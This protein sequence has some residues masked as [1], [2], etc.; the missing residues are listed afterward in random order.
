MWR[1]N[2]E[3]REEVFTVL[4][5]WEYLTDYA[6]RIYDALRTVAYVERRSID[7]VTS[8]IV[9]GATDSGGGGLAVAH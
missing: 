8:D 1:P 2:R 9:Y 4:P 7:E 6:E 5:I 3:F